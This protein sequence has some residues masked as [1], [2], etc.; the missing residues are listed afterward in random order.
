MA[1]FFTNGTCDPYHPISKPCT[2]GNF[3]HYA[4]NVASPAEVVKTLEFAKKHNIRFIIRNTGHEY[5]RL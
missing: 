2:L 1:P 3:V 5:Y 4:V